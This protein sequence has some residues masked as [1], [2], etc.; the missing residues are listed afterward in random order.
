MMKPQAIEQIKVYGET[1]I[2]YGFYEVIIDFSTR[3]KRLMPHV[4]NVPGSEGIRIHGGARTEHTLGCPLVGVR[5]AP[6]SLKDGLQTSQR[7]MDRLTVAL[8]EN[9]VFLTVTK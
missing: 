5:D 2:P 6:E 9:R 4:L 7:F 1:A 3:F 8:K